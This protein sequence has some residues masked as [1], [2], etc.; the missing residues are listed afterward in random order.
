MIKYESCPRQSGPMTS[1]NSSMGKGKGDKMSV[2]GKCSKSR[3]GQ[4]SVLS[5]RT[6]HDDCDELMSCEE[7]NQVSKPHPLTND[8]AYLAGSL[9]GSGHLPSQ[10]HPSGTTQCK[11]H[12]NP[13]LPP[14]SLVM[15]GVGKKTKGD[16]LHSSRTA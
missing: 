14:R 10:H 6:R 3:S 7:G 16:S 4:L 11:R 2:T 9:Y 5:S 12:S 8:N 13:L 1:L 15:G